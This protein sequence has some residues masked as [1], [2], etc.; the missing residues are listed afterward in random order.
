MTDGLDQRL[1]TL[2]ELPVGRP[3]KVEQLQRQATRLR[4]RRRQGRTGVGIVLTAVVVLTVPLVWPSGSREVKVATEGRDQASEGLVSIDQDETT[5]PAELRRLLELPRCGDPGTLESW[6]RSTL[7]EHGAV[8]PGRMVFASASE[9][10][11]TTPFYFRLAGRAACLDVIANGTASAWQAHDA[12]GSLVGRAGSVPQGGDEASEWLTREVS[13]DKELSGDIASGAAL[14][15]IVENGRI[16]ALIEDRA[17]VLEAPLLRDDAESDPWTVRQN[18][19]LTPPEPLTPYDA[20]RLPTRLPPGYRRC[21]GAEVLA[22]DGSQRILYCD[23]TRILELVRLTRESGDQ[24]P[25]DAPLGPDNSERIEVNGLSGLV[26]V[27]GDGRRIVQLDRS[28]LSDQMYVAAPEAEVD[29]RQLTGI[30]ASIPAHDPRGLFPRDGDND[31]RE[32]LRGDRLREVLTAAQLRPVPEATF[33]PGEYFRIT[34][35]GAPRAELVVMPGVDGRP[36]GVS[37]LGGYPRVLA[38]DDVDLIFSPGSSRL[39]P[40]RHRPALGQ[41]VFTCGGVVFNFLGLEDDPDPIVDAARRI[42]SDVDC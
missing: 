4:R 12:Q 29:L 7:A 9:V 23:G 22:P 36:W 10:A 16:D 13:S 31:L 26:G 34:V 11:R 2:R 6:V 25:A 40:G 20:F 24:P 21:S 3:P 28:D 17:M 15:G 19:F 8:D 33:I 38:L 5:V 35:P 39:G 30:A 18:L 42:A 41:A 1:A 37:S 32:V 27:T 14:G